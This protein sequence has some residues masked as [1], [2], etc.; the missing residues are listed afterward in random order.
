MF[1][2]F[3]YAGSYRESKSISIMLLDK[4][5]ARLDALS[6]E[7]IK[8]LVRTPYNSNIEECIGC[9]SCFLTGECPIDDD[10]TFIKQEMLD[11]NLIMLISPVYVHNVPGNVKTLID[12]LGYWTHLMRLCGRFGVLVNISGNNGNEY[13][14]EYLDKIFKYWGIAIVKRTSIQTLRISERAFDSYIENI[15]KTIIQTLKTNEFII[16]NHQ[17]K[18]FQRSKSIYINQM[19]DTAE[20]LYWRN[21]GYFNAENFSQLFNS[22]LNLLKNQNNIMGD[23]E[24][25]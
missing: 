11:S 24:T 23:S 13:V 21:N 1:Q 6:S 22:K 3:A 20:S 9:E 10:M 14:D 18:F 12:R 2:I 16:D 8:F 17:E 15:A 25:S 4:L 5:I 19:I 7:K